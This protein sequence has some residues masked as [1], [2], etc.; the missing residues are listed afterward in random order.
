VSEL[1]PQLA[2]F[3]ASIP[4]LESTVYLASCSQ[5][6][7]SAPVRDAVTSFVQRWD[8]HGLGWEEWGRQVESARAGFAELIN[9]AP[10]DIAIGTSMS[11][12][13]SSVV[14]AYVRERRAPRRRIVSSLGEFPGVAHAWL[15]ARAYGWRVDQLAADAAAPLDPLDV[16]AAV[17]EDTAIVCVP[18]VSY[19]SGGLLELSEVIASAH[20]RGAAVFVD[21]YQSVGTIPVDV[22]ANGADFLASG[23]AKYLCGTPGFTFLYVRP[24]LREQLEPT[25]TGW[26]GRQDPFAFDPATLDYAPGASRFDL[27]SPSVLPGAIAETAIDMIRA[28]GPDRVRAHVENLVAAALDLGGEL[29]LRVLGPKVASARGAMA[30]FDAGSAEEGVRVGEALRERGIVASPRGR[31]VRLSPH[32]FTLDEEMELA[33]REVARLVRG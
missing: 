8:E 28:A 14:S 30:A 1:P 20:A 27:G 5:G 32:G 13:A 29:G 19:Q 33:V 21:A 3:R 24:G 17:D 2:S 25:V 22:R 10:E 26:F 6:P 12:I 11:Q 23:A 16:I 7:L 9:A 18:H 15:G 31:A 4:L